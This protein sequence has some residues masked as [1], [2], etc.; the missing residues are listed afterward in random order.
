MFHLSR[1]IPL[2]DLCGMLDIEVLFADVGELMRIDQYSLMSA[3]VIPRFWVLMLVACPLLDLERAQL[4][5]I[6]GCHT[7]IGTVWRQA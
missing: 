7:S 3:K 4:Q 1:N 2:Y 5:Q 6:L